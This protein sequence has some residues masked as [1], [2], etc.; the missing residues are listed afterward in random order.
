LLNSESICQSN[1]VSLVQGG[2]VIVHAL[3]E[4]ADVFNQSKAF[5]VSE[6]QADVLS[7]DN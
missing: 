1:A 4:E 3:I 7:D 2:A 5:E 6:G